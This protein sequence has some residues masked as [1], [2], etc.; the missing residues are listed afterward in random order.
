[1]PVQMLLLAPA[2]HALMRC[3]PALLR[4]AVFQRLSQADKLKVMALARGGLSV[5]DTH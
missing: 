5:S 2:R 1:M 4:T 3:L